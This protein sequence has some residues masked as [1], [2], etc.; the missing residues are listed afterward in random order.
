[1]PGPEGGCLLPEVPALGGSA[2]R[3]CL[4]E[5]ILGT[6]TAAG[7]TH[8]TGMHSSSKYSSSKYSSTSEFIIIYLGKKTGFRVNCSFNSSVIFVSF[9]MYF[10]TYSDHFSTSTGSSEFSVSVSNSSKESLLSALYYNVK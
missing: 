1:M 5:T 2:P 7:G 8:P 10:S 9:A 4:V 6:A 3:G